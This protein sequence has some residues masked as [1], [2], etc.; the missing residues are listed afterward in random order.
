MP[1]FCC[2]CSRR[3]SRSDEDLQEN[4]Q[5]GSK[6]GKTKGKHD[7]NNVPVSLFTISKQKLVFFKKFYFILHKTILRVFFCQL[8][9]NSHDV[10]TY[11]FFL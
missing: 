9:N 10:Y 3:K 1:W 8:H 2:C 11:S 4:E 5:N 7:N 6:K